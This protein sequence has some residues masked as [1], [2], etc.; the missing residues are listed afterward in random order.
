MKLLEKW[1]LFTEAFFP[2]PGLAWG[3]AYL[4]VTI[5]L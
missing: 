3:Y 5:S 4:T 2:F 1:D